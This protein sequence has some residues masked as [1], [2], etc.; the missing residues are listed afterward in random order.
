MEK[1]I[2]DNLDEFF[3]LSRKKPWGG[4]YAIA[5]TPKNLMAWRQDNIAE[6]L[7]RVLK[8]DD[9][10]EQNSADW[11]NQ[12]SGADVFYLFKVWELWRSISANG[13]KSPVHVHAEA[14]HN[15]CY[16]HPSNNKIEV[17]CEYFPGIPITVL[18]H[19]YDLLVDLYQTENLFW[20]EGGAYCEIT[21]TKE[22]LELYNLDPTDKDLELQ[23]GWDYIK[24]ICAGGDEIWGKL[25]PKARDWRAVNPQ[26]HVDDD[27]WENALFLTV[28]DRYHRVAMFNS[29]KQLKDIIAVKPGQAR[30]CG[31]WYDIDE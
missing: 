2:R 23:F 4:L 28:T 29:N 21:N 5:C 9:W 1:N 11:S 8:T 15:N 27:R 16:F 25:K 30:F 10:R 31:K 13:V 7:I 24:N 17:L 20:Y 12:N 6:T 26:D 18:W 14:G 3:S 19:D 22:Y